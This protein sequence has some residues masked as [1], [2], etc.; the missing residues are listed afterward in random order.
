LRKVTNKRC[1]SEGEISVYDYTNP[2]T[3]PKIITT[4]ALTLTNPHDAFES[5]CSMVVCEFVRNYSCTMDGAMV[6]SFKV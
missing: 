1:N 3:N 6:T 5:F 4:L 2:N